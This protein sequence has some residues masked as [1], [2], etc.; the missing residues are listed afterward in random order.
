MATRIDFGIRKES[1][2]Q[3]ATFMVTSGLISEQQLDQAVIASDESNRGLMET[4]LE[5]GFTAEKNIASSIGGMY[6]LETIW[7]QRL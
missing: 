3:L 6:E 7:H 1:A 5:F 4:I 2:A